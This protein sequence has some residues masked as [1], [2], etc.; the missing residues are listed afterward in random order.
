MPQDPVPGH[1][2]DDVPSAAAWQ[3]D[4]GPQGGGIGVAARAVGGYTAFEQ[5]CP[6][7]G[8]LASAPLAAVLD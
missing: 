1:G 5:G 3:P 7:D 6:L 4:P 2:R 8:E